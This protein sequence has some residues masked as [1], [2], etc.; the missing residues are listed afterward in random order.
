MIVRSRNIF[1][2]RT[3]F[4][5]ERLERR[6]FLERYHEYR[7]GPGEASRVDVRVCAMAFP[8][9]VLPAGVVI[10]ARRFE[11]LHHPRRNDVVADDEYYFH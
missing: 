5:N 2:G 4:L 11:E 7:V 6:F 8:L 10:D 1:V 3:D 9:N